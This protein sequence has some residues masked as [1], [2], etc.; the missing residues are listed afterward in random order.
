MALAAGTNECIACDKTMDDGDGTKLSTANHPL[1]P[2]Q[3]VTIKEVI[4]QLLH[5]KKV[6]AD[7]NSSGISPDQL[8]GDK[9]EICGACLQLLASCHRQKFPMET[10]GMLRMVIRVG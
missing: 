8:I 5:K 10:G 2:R 6:R 7:P 3:A 1:F 9:E 4:I